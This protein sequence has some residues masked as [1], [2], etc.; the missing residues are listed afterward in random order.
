MASRPADFKSLAPLAYLYEI[1]AGKV[2]E[3]PL[4]APTDARI[5]HTFRRWLANAMVRLARRIYPQSAAVRSFYVDR[6][7][8]LAITGQSIVKVQV[9][10]PREIK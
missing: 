10:D 4:K 9:V 6:M 8:D 3:M 1:A 2:T 5:M 7:V